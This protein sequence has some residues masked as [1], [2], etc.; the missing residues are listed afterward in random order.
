MMSSGVQEESNVRSRLEEEKL[1]TAL[2][3]MQTFSYLLRGLDS[4]PSTSCA[5]VIMM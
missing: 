2:P 1:F 3:Y 5:W 4:E